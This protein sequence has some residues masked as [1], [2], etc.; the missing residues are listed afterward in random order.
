MA[1]AFAGLRGG[2]EQPRSL[3]I[4]RMRSAAFCC[5]EAQR[6]STAF[7]D[8]VK[9]TKPWSAHGTCGKPWLDPSTQGSGIRGGCFFSVLAFASSEFS[10]TCMNYYLKVEFRSIQSR[11]PHSIGL[12]CLL[13]LLQ[14]VTVLRSFLVSR[15]LDPLAVF[16][17]CICRMTLSL[18]LSD[19]CLD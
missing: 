16:C 14:P 9:Q 7:S 18:V 6:L 8:T 12:S 17:I 1:I 5:P 13:I 15:D 19:V 2:K 4:M 10:T 11:I 3:R